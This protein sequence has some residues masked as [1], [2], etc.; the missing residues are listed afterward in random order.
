M[1]A[2][3]SV[4]DSSHCIV[5]LELVVAMRESIR[6]ATRFIR[7]AHAACCAGHLPYPILSQCKGT[8]GL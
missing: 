4:F 5:G 6:I 7:R 3:S 2:K 8:K 1:L